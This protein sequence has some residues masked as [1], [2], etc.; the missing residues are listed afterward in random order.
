MNIAADDIDDDLQTI[1]LRQWHTLRSHLR[2]RTG[3]IE[4]AEDALQETWLRVAGLSNPP[5]VRDKRAFLLRI[6]GNIA[7]DIIRRER[8]HQSRCTADENILAAIEDLAPSPEKIAID[9]DHLRAL[10]SALMELPE[11]ARTALLMSRCD[12]LS[13]REI[14]ARLKVSESMVAKYLAQSLRHCRYAFRALG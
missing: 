4:V 6:A 13:H 12:G 9:R 8:R 5:I 3:S 11:K 14:A 10:V 2:R 7:I 1:Y